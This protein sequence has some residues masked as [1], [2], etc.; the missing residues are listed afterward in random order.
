MS[1]SHSASRLSVMLDDNHAAGDARLALVATLS[2]KLGL[3]EFAEELVD[4]HPFPE[5][6]SLRSCTRL[7]PGQTAPT[8]CT[9]LAPP[10]CSATW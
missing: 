1:S 10:R 5:R 9:P 4:V 6:A 7:S 2:E 3:E 8:C